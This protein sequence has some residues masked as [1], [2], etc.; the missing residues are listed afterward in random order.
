MM[1]SII[2]EC[3][4]WTKV[5]DIHED[6]YDYGV[7]RLAVP[8]LVCTVA[9]WPDY[10]PPADATMRTVDAYRTPRSCNN[11]TIFEVKR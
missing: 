1:T 10:G 4:G 8:E 6:V 11:M 9:L 2:V 7:L 5:M 3:D